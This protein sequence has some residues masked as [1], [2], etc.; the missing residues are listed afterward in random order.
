M[1]ATF[2]PCPRLAQAPPT[3]IA[4]KGGENAL[5]LLTERYQ[6]H[7]MVI[8]GYGAGAE[9]RRPLGLAVVGGLLFFLSVAVYFGVEWR[10]RRRARQ[11]HAGTPRIA[12]ELSR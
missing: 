11:A 12:G 2:R 9:S 7:P 8:R 6:P 1:S 5:A 4:I 10:N 3:F